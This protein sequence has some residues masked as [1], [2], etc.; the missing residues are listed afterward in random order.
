M[1]DYDAGFNYL[2]CNKCGT[3]Y[4]AVDLQDEKHGNDIINCIGGKYPMKV[5]I[6]G[7]DGSVVEPIRSS[8][9]ITPTRHPVE[10]KKHELKVRVVEVPAETAKTHIEKTVEK[11]AVAP[12]TEVVEE[13]IKVNMRTA[14]IEK[15]EPEK[16]EEPK[17]ESVV[18]PK[19]PPVKKQ[20]SKPA[21]EKKEV[22]TETKAEPVNEEPVK[23]EK[24]VKEEPSKEEPERVSESENG[25][26][27]KNPEADK[28]DTKAQS[29]VPN[30]ADFTPGNDLAYTIEESGR[31]GNKGY[32]KKASTKK[33]AKTAGKAKT[34]SK[35]SGTGSRFIPSPET[36]ES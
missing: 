23:E 15:T 9:I 16:K 33:T 34:V 4:Y 20:T 14:S 5:R 24:P 6:V 11:V 26:E 32:P 2:L 12:K 22:K 36:S 17:L 13:T 7:S 30:P 27:I 21:S 29:Y 1:I 25:E 31:A 28:D 10:K 19:A 18:T 3:R 35:S 8:N